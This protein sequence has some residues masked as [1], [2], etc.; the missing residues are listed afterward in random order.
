MAQV[1]VEVQVWSLTQLRGLKDLV[2]SPWPR[3][4]HIPWVWP[5]KQRP[6]NNEVQRASRL[7]NTPCHN[8]IG[9]EAPILRTLPDIGPMN[10]FIWLFICIPYHKPGNHWFS[11]TLLQAILTNYWT[12]MGGGGV[13]MRTPLVYSRLG[14]NVGSLAIPFVAGIWNGTSL[15]GQGPLTCVIWCWL[16]VDSIRIEYIYIYIY[17]FFWL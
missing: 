8:S 17:I 16:Q 3:N 2:F 13:V 6:M 12:W 4:F 14:R 15:V 10:P 11:W 7:V 9:T 1:T 5:L